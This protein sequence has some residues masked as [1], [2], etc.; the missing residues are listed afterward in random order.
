MGDILIHV[1]AVEDYTKVPNLKYV[2]EKLLHLVEDASRFI[3]KYKS[4]GA[5][6]ETRPFYVAYELVLNRL[7]STCN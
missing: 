3:L 6:G 1:A 5:T 4:D 2:I 7:Q